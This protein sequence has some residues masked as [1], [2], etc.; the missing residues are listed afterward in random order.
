MKRE[1]LQ[2]H[3]EVALVCEIGISKVEALN[4]LSIPQINKT[5]LA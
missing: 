5:I 4:N 3:K 1:T 2:K